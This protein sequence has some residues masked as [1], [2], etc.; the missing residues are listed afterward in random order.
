ML[1]V[2]LLAI[3]KKRLVWVVLFKLQGSYLVKVRIPKGV[4]KT[5]VHLLKKKDFNYAK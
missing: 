3:K 4:E 2:C 5:Q 1:K